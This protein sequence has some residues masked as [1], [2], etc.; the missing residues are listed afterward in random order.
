[1]YYDYE[2]GTEVKCS[3][4]CSFD[5][6]KGRQAANYGMMHAP[7]EIKCMGVF[8]NP[9]YVRTVQAHKVLKMDRY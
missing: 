5:E 9:K 2:Q 6:Q 1:M 3:L 8:T 7:D 4:I